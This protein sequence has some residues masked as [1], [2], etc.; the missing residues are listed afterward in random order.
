LAQGG[1]FFESFFK[2]VSGV[3]DS[4]DLIPGHGGILDRIDGLAF[5]L[6]LAYFIF[7]QS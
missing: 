6:P 4:G 2:R 1:D 7:V 3:K 5:T